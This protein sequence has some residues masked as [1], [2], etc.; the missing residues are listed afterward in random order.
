MLDSSPRGAVAFGGGAGENVSL[1]ER[2]ST[3]E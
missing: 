1:K 2:L 3:A